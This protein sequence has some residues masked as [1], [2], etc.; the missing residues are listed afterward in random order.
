MASSAPS[1][2]AIRRNDTCLLN[3]V[4]CGQTVAPWRACCPAGAS[5]PSQYNPNCCPSSLN[6]TQSL[7]R[8]PNCANASWTLYDNAGFFCCAPGAI[9]YASL[10]SNSDGCADPG[11]SPEN[12]RLLSV[13]SAGQSKIQRSCPCHGKTLRIGV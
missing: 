5:C 6:C 10:F 4:D 7:L 12:I 11:S 8:N 9:G 3:E 1:G 13:V 2:F